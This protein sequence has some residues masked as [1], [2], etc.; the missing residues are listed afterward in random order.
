MEINK[1][2]KKNLVVLI[3]LVIVFVGPL[4]FAWVTLKRA[5]QSSFKTTNHGMLINPPISISSIEFV[6][7]T[8]NSKLSIDSL[9]GKWQL[10]Y[11]GPNRCNEQCHNSLYNLKQ[12]HTAL[13]KQAVRVNKLF[14]TVPDCKINECDKY[15]SEHYPEFDRLQIDEQNFAKLFGKVSNSNDRAMLGEIYIIDPMGNL[16]MQYSADTQAKGILSDLKRLLT[17]S[18]IG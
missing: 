1:K 12:I 14:I 9:K 15:I 18:K 3:L 6:D 8:D 17:A 7:L 16:M 4:L 13:N 10:I 2:N 5:E 11:L